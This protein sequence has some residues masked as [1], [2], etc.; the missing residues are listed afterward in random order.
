MTVRLALPRSMCTSKAKS[1]LNCSAEITMNVF[2]L[3]KCGILSVLSGGV[4]A[5]RMV[6]RKA[7]YFRA[8]L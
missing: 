7:K 1:P 5:P 8:S 6:Q 3:D 4:I 2:S